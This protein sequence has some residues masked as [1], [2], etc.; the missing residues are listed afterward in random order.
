MTPTN[1]N[2]WWEETARQIRT[3]GEAVCRRAQNLEHGGGTIQLENAVK[4]EK[5][6]LTNMKQTNTE[7]VRKRQ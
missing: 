7:K 1:V 3:C 6:R 2:E 5:G 4:E